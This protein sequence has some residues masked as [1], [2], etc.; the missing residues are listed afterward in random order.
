V[1]IVSIHP[2]G[3]EI[4][5]PEGEAVLAG[6]YGAGYAYSIGCR[7]GGCGVCKV[8]LLAGRVSYLHT[9]A[10]TVLSAEERAAGVCLTCRAV[11]ETDVTLRFRQGAL[12]LIQPLLRDLNEAARL[13]VAAE[14]SKSEE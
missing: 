12:R 11:P 5:L 9:L 6:L 7:R 4:Y 8:D 10:T 1:P 2:T 14:P 3:E 13:R